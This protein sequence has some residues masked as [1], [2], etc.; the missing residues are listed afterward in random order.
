MAISRDLPGET[1]SAARHIP[2]HAMRRTEPSALAKFVRERL[3]EL[4]MKQSE[5]CRLTGF[6]QGL[7][8]KIQNSMITSLSIESALRLS[9]G[10]GVS[11]KKMFQLIDRMDL[12]EMVMEAYSSEFKNN[13]R[14]LPGSVE[15]IVQLS[16]RAHNLGRDLGS[17]IG[18]LQGLIGKEARSS[19]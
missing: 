8:S 18:S 1:Q 4:G 19:P 9:I 11:P 17:I 15:E 7:L 16:L 14:T 5:F 2:R 10:L 13:V 12:D 3:A 6:D